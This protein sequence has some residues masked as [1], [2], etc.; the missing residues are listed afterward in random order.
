M[1][2]QR[3]TSGL[4]NQMYQYAFFRY[5]QKHYPDEIIKADLT[6][7]NW[8][9]EHQGFELERLFKVGLPAAGRAEVLRC[10]GALPKDFAGARY[11]NRVI[12]LFA[13][14]KFI[15]QHIDEMV[16]GQVLQTGRNWYVTGFY[17]SEV[18]YKKQLPELRNKFH[19]PEFESSDIKDM[20]DNSD[21]VSIHVRRGDYLNP[22]YSGK[23]VNLDMDYYKKAVEIVRTKCRKPLFFVFSDDKDYIRS[24]FEW[25]DNKVIVEGNDGHDS[26]KDMY[27]MSLCHHN[28]IANSTFSQW[29]AL[30]NRNKDAMVI[31]PHQY[32]ADQDVEEKTTDGW[33]CI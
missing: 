7:F 9:D 30:L 25:L 20:I 8:H 6:W 17:T 2:L 27:L 22:I 33:V 11:V 29:G 18:Y 16:P 24:S 26:W 13:E 5:L 19:F 31:Y 12:R 1:I 23:F 10:S 21:A 3:F 4:G 28:I 14:Q 15:K 32:L